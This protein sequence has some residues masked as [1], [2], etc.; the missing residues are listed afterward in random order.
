MG[1]VIDIEQERQ[2]ARLDRRMRTESAAAYVIR[3]WLGAGTLEPTPPSEQRR[4]PYRKTAAVRKRR[5]QATTTSGVRS[6][7]GF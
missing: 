1:V 7:S 6:S 3:G 5:R 4:R 2:R